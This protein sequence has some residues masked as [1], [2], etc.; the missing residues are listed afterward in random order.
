MTLASELIF[1][2]W[3][4]RTRCYRRARRCSRGS[5]RVKREMPSNVSRALSTDTSTNRYREAAQAFALDQSGARCTTATPSLWVVFAGMRGCFQ[6]PRRSLR[7]PSSSCR[8]PQLFK[9]ETC[10]LFRTNFTTE[11]NEHRSFAFNSH[12]HSL[13]RGHYDLRKALGILALRARACGSTR[14]KTRFCPANQPHPRPR[15]AVSEY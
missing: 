5:Q 13:N 1:D 7:S 11:L 15:S 4:L 8:L 12:R 9:P 14:S 2:R 3:I 6:P 10:E